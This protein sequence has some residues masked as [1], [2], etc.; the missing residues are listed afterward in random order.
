MASYSYSPIIGT[1]YEITSFADNCCQQQVSL[2]T[3]SGPVD[4]ILSSDTYVVNHEM[5]RPG[6]TIAAFYD[7][8]Q[9]VPLIYPPRYQAVAVTGLSD[10]E[11]VAFNYFNQNLVASDNSLMLNVTASTQVVASNGETYS[12]SPGNNL[13]LVYY[14]A[15]TRSIPARTTPDKIIV[16]CNK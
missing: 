2:N 14:R 8:N 16:F 1:I 3:S 6:M 11:N 9:P 13:L 15:S 5:L 4:F 12:C 7:P 10:G